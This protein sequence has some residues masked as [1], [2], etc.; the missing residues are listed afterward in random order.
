MKKILFI[1]TGNTCRS[2]MAEVLLR[3]KIHKAGLQEEMAVGSAGLAAQQNSQATSTACL[4]VKQ[5]GLSL[6]DHRANV[7][8][9]DLVE[10]ADLILTMTADHRDAILRVVP[11]ARNKIFTLQ[12]YA[13]TIGEITDPYGGDLNRYLACLRD[14]QENI[15]H[16]WGKIK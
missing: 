7:L 8:T 16:I 13:G 11:G 10:A 5:L 9:L 1:C 4:A 15:D 14:L 12:Q 3:A 6:E 2:P